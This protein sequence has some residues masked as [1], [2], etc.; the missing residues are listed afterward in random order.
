MNTSDDTLI[1]I[2]CSK[3]GMKTAKPISWIRH[4]D[5]LICPG[6]NSEIRFKHQQFV[7]AVGEAEKAL[8]QLRRTLAKPGKGSR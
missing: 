2:P 5:A 1:P 8:A 7:Q 6:C 4:N 3:C